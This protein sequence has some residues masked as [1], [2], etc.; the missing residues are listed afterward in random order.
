MG[1]VDRGAEVTILTLVY[2][3]LR[4]LDFVMD[5]VDGSRNKA[6]YRWLVVANNASEGVL[7]GLSS[8]RY[9]GLDWVDYDYGDASAHYI[10]RVY[11]AW[12]EGVA[13]AKTPWV[14]LVNTDMR[15]GDWAIDELVSWKRRDPMSLPCGL[16]VENGRI[17]SAMPEYCR[18]FGTTPETFHRKGWENHAAALY[19]KGAE[20]G[21]PGRLFQPCLVDRQEFFD[22]G[23]YPEE[24]NVGGVSGDKIL[25]DRYVACGFDWVT[26]LGSVW[27]HCQEGEMRDE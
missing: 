23:G 16:L 25:F 1:R 24:G 13:L 21:E 19:N 4:W 3:D 15:P 18:D 11:A 26:C 6:D 22:M 17:P 2:K 10:R 20:R 7:D 27:M 8:N 9:S 12:R 14:I 5:G